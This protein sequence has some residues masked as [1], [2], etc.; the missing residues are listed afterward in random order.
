MFNCNLV[1]GMTLTVKEED[2]LER[3]DNFCYFHLEP[4]RS[5]GELHNNLIVEISDSTS[6]RTR[7]VI[8]KKKEVLRLIKKTENQIAKL[9]KQ[10]AGNKVEFFINLQ[11]YLKGI[12]KEMEELNATE[13]E[14][15]ESMAIL[16][17]YVRPESAEQQPRIIL[18]INTIRNCRV[19]NTSWLLAEVYVHEMHHAW[20]DHNLDVD[21]NYIKEIEEP[22]TELGMLLFMEQ[23]DVV[24]KGIKN[25]A[26]QH[27]N[28]KKIGMTSCYGFGAYL[29]ESSKRDWLNAYYYA[30]YNIPS[31]SKPIDEYKAPFVNGAYPINEEKWANHLWKILTVAPCSSSSSST[32]ATTS[33]PN[34]YNVIDKVSSKVLFSH[35]HM[36]K[37]VM[38]IVEDYCD[39]N[40]SITFSDLQMIF[41]SI[42]PYTPNYL[43]MIELKSEVDRYEA[44]RGID[45]LDR[46]FKDHPIVLASGDIIYVTS[47]WT[48]DGNFSDFIKAVDSIRYKID[49]I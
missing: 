8:Y 40:P 29:F 41:G 24:E 26:L 21:G 35:K 37:V 16:G 22:L 49:I 2:V 11:N 18:Y 38:W 15:K 17:E 13:L 27:V 20:Y 3:V 1:K 9:H 6:D 43:H 14:K 45:T 34:G 36:T 46:F 12:L 39:N 33:K 32:P 23:L 25:E 31:P 47:E 19:I 42:H 10:G 7:T 28:S 5:L 44:A 4:Y 48:R 30:K